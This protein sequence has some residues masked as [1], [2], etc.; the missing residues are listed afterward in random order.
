LRR[1]T[2]LILALVLGASWAPRLTAQT[3][4]APVSQ[5]TATQQAPEK[6]LTAA[7][8]KELLASVPQMLEFSSQDTG[9]AIHSKVKGRITSRDAVEKFLNDKL[10][11]DKDAKRMERSELVMKKFGLHCS[12]SRSPA[13]TTTRRRP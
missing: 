10:K 7:Q 2:I 4:T 6:L 12:R 11:N 13:T 8:S 3:T 1:R 9:L 5:P